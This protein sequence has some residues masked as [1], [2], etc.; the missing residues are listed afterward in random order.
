MALI[1]LE[2][3]LKIPKLEGK[4]YNILELL[5]FLSL[6]M[7]TEP[8]LVVHCLLW[9]PQHVES[10]HSVQDHDSR[11]LTAF[12]TFPAKVQSATA[13]FMQF[14]LSIFSSL[15]EWIKTSKMCCHGLKW[16]G[17]SS[18]APTLSECELVGRWNR[19]NGRE[20]F[21]NIRVCLGCS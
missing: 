17:Q 10:L 4:D 11:D 16:W 2:P 3:S 21:I 18:W 6:F 15:H 9:S 13:L 19:G 12:F 8:F 7:M 20:K 1:P 5:E 14:C